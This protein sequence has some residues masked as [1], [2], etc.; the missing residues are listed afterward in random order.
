MVVALA[1]R[2]HVK[3]EQIFKMTAIS[4]DCKPL[5]PTPCSVK[6]V[7]SSYL[8]INA[9]PPPHV[10]KTLAIYAKN[11]AD[12]EK[13]LKISDSTVVEGEFTYQ[14]YVKES[15]R[16]ILDI[17]LDFP[18]VKI[19]F[20]HFVELMPKL[21][22]RY[23]SISSS[24]KAFPK[25]I[26]ITMVVV[27]YKTPVG[28]DAKGL[29]TYWLQ[30]LPIGTLIPIFVRTS[31]LR[32]PKNPNIPIIMVGPGTGIAPFRG[33]IQDRQHDR[34]A[35]MPQEAEAVL[36]YGCR[37][38]NLDY[39]YKTELEEHTNNGDISRLFIAFSRAIPNQKVY[40]QNKMLEN[41]A[42]ICTL[43]K[44][45]GA[46][47]YICGDSRMARD[48]HSVLIKILQEC[49]EFTEEEA[50]SFIKNLSANSRFQQDIW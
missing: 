24:G 21:A 15:I 28:R 25:T 10:V 14:K 23:Y 36:F 19:P 18:S 4:S 47:F 42:H 43:L 22:P 7:L 39:L 5:F 34:V 29:C 17:L 9:P 38:S 46:H 26:H 40:V 30:Q 20:G 32:P 27:R 12:K 2:L 1:K 11:E 41:K 16:T 13:L 33:F 48:V 44:D 37:D 50:K 6:T 45:K 35:G 49:G 31:S 8:D 3:L